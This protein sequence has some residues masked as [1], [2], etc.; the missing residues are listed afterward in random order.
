METSPTGGASVFPSATYKKPF[1]DFDQMIDL[2]ITRGMVI[3][4][5]NH[6]A[7]MLQSIGYYRLSGYWFSWRERI[8]AHS[9]D[10][11]RGDNFLRNCNFHDLIALYEFDSR[12]RSSLLN[13]VA[14]LEVKLRATLA[15]YT[16]KHDHYF[17]LNRDS[18]SSFADTIPGSHEETNYERLI[19]RSAELIDRSSEVFVEHFRS[20]YDGM[21]P[22]WIAVETW[23]LGMLATCTE[24]LKP[25]WKEEVAEQFAM[26]LHKPLGGCF[27]SLNQLRNICA[28]QGRIYRRVI[29]PEPPTKF[30][31]DIPNLAHVP[32]IEEIQRR[33]KVYPTLAWM[34]HALQA[35]P[36]YSVWFDQLADTLNG[37]PKMPNASLND[38]GFPDDWRH[39]QLWD[40]ML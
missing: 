34:V 19:R 23:D 36:Q 13:G 8:D 1:L 27:K 32:A 30:M 3:E 39:Q 4:D 24:M 6:A 26:P 29:K 18:Y 37:F 35:H 16:G 10:E 33:N 7:L 17:Y 40:G 11:H 31:R 20:R 5:R 28:H 21:P 15:H 25:S 9:H 14:L 2:L 22:I 38:Y 12:L